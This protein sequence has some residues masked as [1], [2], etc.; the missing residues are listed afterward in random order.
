[1]S[2]RQRRARRSGASISVRIANRQCNR[3]S[4]CRDPG[5]NASGTSRAIVSNR[6]Y[7]EPHM[8]VDFGARLVE[9]PPA[10]RRYATKPARNTAEAEDLVQDPVLRAWSRQHLWDPRLGQL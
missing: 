4:L 10:L 1:M 5:P 2:G 8:E 3:A 6:R 7:R 9:Q